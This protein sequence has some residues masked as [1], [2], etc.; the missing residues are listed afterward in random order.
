MHVRLPL[1]TFRPDQTVGI[2]P[3]AH[4]AACELQW[5]GL[6]HF[7]LLLALLFCPAL[8]LLVYNNNDCTVVCCGNCSA[9]IA[10]WP[11]YTFSLRFHFFKFSGT[12]I[13]DNNHCI[14]TRLLILCLCPR[15]I[16]PTHIFLGSIGMCVRVYIYIHTHTWSAVQINL[17]L[18]LDF[19]DWNHLTIKIYLRAGMLRVHIR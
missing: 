18:L 9:R 15:R 8:E 7:F 12:F 11:H 1:L 19:A 16:I 13:Y 2:V 14:V 10:L 5:T 3:R 4:G 6:V 17:E